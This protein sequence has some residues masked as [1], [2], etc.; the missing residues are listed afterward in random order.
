MIQTSP[1]G[2]IFPEF[3]SKLGNKI[4]NS[5]KDSNDSKSSA[6]WNRYYKETMKFMD[7]YKGEL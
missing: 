1:N 5:D 7:D 4:E 2:H 3:F 6:L